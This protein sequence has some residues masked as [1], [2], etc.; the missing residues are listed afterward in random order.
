MLE[1]FHRS[2]LRPDVDWLDFMETLAGQ[3][4]IA[5]ENAMLLKELQRT[6]FEL[7]LAYNTTIEGWSRALDLRDRDTEGHTERVTDLAIKLA[8]RLGLGECR[9]GPRAARS[10][11]ARHR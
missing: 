6:N 7:T 8:R 5:V 10:H 4:A 3:A 2:H 9:A 1:I 11:P